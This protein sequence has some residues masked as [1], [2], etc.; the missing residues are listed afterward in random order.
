[1]PT[2]DPR[3]VQPIA[4]HRAKAW[5]QRILVGNRLTRLAAPAPPFR[6]LAVGTDQTQLDHQGGDQRRGQFFPASATQVARQH[7]LA[8][9]RADETADG[10]PGHLEHAP[11]F[12]VATLVQGRAIPFVAAFAAQIFKR[13]ELGRTIF[14]FDAV[15]QARL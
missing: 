14:E 13:T 6:A 7:D 2:A 4:L 9:A 15:H 12:A 8:E 10:D 1:A 11:H 5:W 3:T